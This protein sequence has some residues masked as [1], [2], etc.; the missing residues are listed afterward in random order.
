M[1]GGSGACIF[2]CI[3]SPVVLENICTVSVGTSAAVVF[4]WYF[5]C[6]LGCLLSQNTFHVLEIN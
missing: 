6:S 3:N 2:M 4:V 1:L 5:Y